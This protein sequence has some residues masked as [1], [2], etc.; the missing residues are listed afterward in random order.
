MDASSDRPIYLDHN[1]TTPVLPEAVEVM[2]S[3]FR[4]DYGNPSS[5]HC[6]GRRARRAVDRARRQVATLIGASPS[7]VVFTSGGT[8]SNNLA[9]AGVCQANAEPGRVVTS[10]IEHPSV[11]Q[12]CRRLQQRGWEVS[13]VSVDD[14]GLVDVDEAI[15][16][17]GSDTA[18]VTIMHSN[19]E[20]GA[21]QPL[22]PIVERA[23][24]VGAVVHTD[25]AQ[26]VGKVDI[27]VDELG[28]DLMTIAGH[29]VY[30]P[31]GIGVLYVRD[32]TELEPVLTG[33]GHE[34]GLRPGTENVPYIAALGKACQVA[35][36]RGAEERDR[37]R[38]LRQRLWRRL[39]EEIDGIG[40]NGVLDRCL[41]NTLNV[42]FPDVQASELLARTPEIAASTGSACKEGSGGPSPVLNAMGLTR[43][44]ALG[45][46]RLSLGCGN[47]EGEIERAARLL[48]R[49][50]RKSVSDDSPDQPVPTG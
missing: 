6:Y 17:I 22:E 13:R 16:A 43:Q 39:N 36:E 48:G 14:T 25:A 49:A 33:A 1:A 10:T 41:P 20:T 11:V 4:G 19:N 42:R 45:S 35:V 30:A 2:M 3:F 15:G 8:E 23:Q 32:G 46:M 44:E 29:K 18:L 34:H 50:F 37:I 31:K 21:V 27:D 38:K 5:T 12:P 24:E 28:V 7:E 9:I 47:D 26:S 40:L